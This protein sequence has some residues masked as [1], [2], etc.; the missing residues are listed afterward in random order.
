[1][2]ENHPSLVEFRASK[3]TK[4]VLSYIMPPISDGWFLTKIRYRDISDE[5]LAKWIENEKKKK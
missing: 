5:E 3:T 1:M 2:L 4:C